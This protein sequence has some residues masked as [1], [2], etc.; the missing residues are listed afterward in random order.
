MKPVAMLYCQHSLGLGHFVRSLALAEALSTEFD[1]L[2]LN[3]GPVPAGFSLPPTV[4]FLN[5][6]PLRLE[7][8]GTLSGTG[9]VDDI[10]LTRRD[11]ICAEAARLKPALLIVE[12]YPFGRKK[13]APEIEPLI[14]TIRSQ[15]GKIVCS[16]RD[17]L[18]TQRVD[19][20]RHD[21]RAAQRLNALF[22]MVIV[23]SD[24]ALFNLAGSFRPATP[25][26]IPV[27]YS[28]Y[29][30]RPTDYED[31]R[32]LDM[33]LV[34][35]GGGAVGMPLYRVAV[36]A[37]R[38]LHMKQGW[39]MTLVAG[40]LLPET[41]WE[42]LNQLAQ[43]TDGLTLHRSVPSLQPL[44][45]RS[46]RFAGQCGYNSAL[47][48]LQSR[49]PA[50]FVPFARGQESEQ[51]ERARTLASLGQA[52]WLHPD[53]LTPESLAE[54]LLR[55]APPSALCSIDLRGAANSAALLSELVS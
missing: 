7:E 45:S 18:V 16:V 34:A 26:R 52:E 32:R 6:P 11:M 27:S 42:E 37:Q 9:P 51:T 47:E 3:G 2:F 46:A 24:P 25:V 54:R 33:T 23:H 36:A 5:L 48:I 22:D 8:D 10:L 31:E 17:I 49:T 38:E 44:I 40:P 29:I 12:L 19:Q 21:E 35:A 4:R 53:D 14:A 50:L 20:A 41:E 43:G 55:L 28:G 15:G 1:M 13:F 39:S 30:V